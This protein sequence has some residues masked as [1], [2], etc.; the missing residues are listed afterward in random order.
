MFTR[1]AF[2]K[3]NSIA[4]AGV[5]IAGAAPLVSTPAG[6]QAAAP[7]ADTGCGKLRGRTEKGIHLFRGVPYGAP[8]SGGN[9]FMPPHQPVPWRGTRDALEWGHIAPQPLP[10]GNWDYT[11]AC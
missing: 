1:R 4:A 3:Q 10:N 5:W 2:L 7:I 8:T 6:A 11:H 9:R